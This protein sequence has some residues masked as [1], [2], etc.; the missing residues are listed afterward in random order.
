MP[1][2]PEPA[3]QLAETLR[4][5][6]ERFRLL[7]ENTLDLIVEVTPDGQILYVSPNI[8]QVLGYTAN[9]FVGTNAYDHVHPDDLPAVQ[10][11]FALPSE[12]RVT[13]RCRHRDGSWRWLDTTGRDYLTS[14]GQER[15]VLIARDVT[16]VKLTEAERDQLEAKL[17]KAEKLCALGTLAGGVAHDFNNILTAIMAYTNLARMDTHQA[18]VRDSLTHVLRA[19]DR[20]K[21]LT[22]QILT[23]SSQQKQKRVAARLSNVAQEVV[24]LLRPTMPGTIE[25]VTH[26]SEDV[27]SVLA[28]P[29]QIHQV[30]VNLCT[31]AIHAMRHQAG[32][33]LE[34]RVATVVVDAALAQSRSGLRPGPH[35][36]L[37][38]IDTGHGMN[39]ETRQRIF[40]PL[41]TTKKPG[42]GTGLGLAVVHRIVTDHGGVIQVSSRPGEGTT[43]HLLFPLCDEPS[44]TE[45]HDPKLRSHGERVLLVD[46]EASVCETAEKILRNANYLVTTH[47]DPR[48]ALEIFRARPGEFDLMITDL[49]MP[50]LTGVD[51]A[52]EILK[53]RP[54]LPVLLASGAFG[55]WTVEDA[56]RHGIRGILAKPFQSASLLGA[57]RQALHDNPPVVAE[58]AVKLLSPGAALFPTQP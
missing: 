44:G 17:Y 31:N 4:Q 23:F 37:S 14:A 55:R 38:V 39:A 2:D 35:A 15:G 19:A 13:C 52:V 21:N 27:G 16:A 43:F 29:T 54:L 12:H 6:S 46:D 28:D 53:L 48:H 34:V 18:S 11:R 9:E 32:G 1:F 45:T 41:F 49:A 58:P 3:P 47:T 36:C 30:I 57:A 7:V 5:D 20:A 33:R 50:G 40:E 10:A 8:R 22:Q 51:L 42:E 25:V 56:R 24:N 26:L